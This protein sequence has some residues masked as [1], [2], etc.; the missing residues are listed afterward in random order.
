MKNTPIQILLIEDSPFAARRTEDMLKESE[1]SRFSSELTCADRL[2]EG[3]RCLAAGGVDIILLDLMLPDSEAM[4]TFN[5]VKSKALNVPIII[6]SGQTDETLAIKTVQGGA[7]DYLLKHL[8]SSELLKRS[9]LY[10]IKRNR[11]RRQIE[12]LNDELERRLTELRETN[13]LLEAFSH[14][15]SHDLQTPLRA[16]DGFS[17]MLVED[18]TDRLDDEGKRLLNVIRSNT[19]KMGQFIKDLLDFSRSGRQEMH[20]MNIDMGHLAK[21][22]FEELKMPV[23]ERTLQLK[24]KPLPPARGDRAMIRAV[25]VNL[26]SNAVKFTEPKETAVIEV[27]GKTQ[28]GENRYYVKDNGVGF[29]MRS[30]GKLFDSFQRLHSTDEFE[31]TG[32]GLAIVQRII[33]RHGGRVQARGKVGKGATFSFTLPIGE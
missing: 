17:H 29:D 24:M 31:G 20:K 10:S 9:I 14:S 18:Y 7:Q 30:A 6:M 27:G 16:I 4:D 5:A 28:K 3:L 11:T 26:L 32:V 33:H 21:E 8:V 12:K 23:P 13:K 15:V 25:F 2:S 1:D 22:V 19:N